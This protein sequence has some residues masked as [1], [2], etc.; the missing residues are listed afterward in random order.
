MNI[1][2]RFLTAPLNCKQTDNIIFSRTKNR[3]RP[4]RAEKKCSKKLF[5]IIHQFSP[6]L[7]KRVNF[8]TLLSFGLW[9]ELRHLAHVLII[10]SEKRIKFVATSPNFWEGKSLNFRQTLKVKFLSLLEKCCFFHWKVFFAFP[11]FDRPEFFRA[12]Q[13]F[14]DLPLSR[15]NSETTSTGRNVATSSSLTSSTSSRSPDQVFVFNSEWFCFGSV[16]I[17]REKVKN[18]GEKIGIKRFWPKR[19]LIERWFIAFMV[20]RIWSKNEFAETKN[21]KGWSDGRCRSRPTTTKTRFLVGTELIRFNKICPSCK[22]ASW[23]L[24]KKRRFVSFFSLGES[25]SGNCLVSFLHLLILLLQRVFLGAWFFCR[26][27]FFY[28]LEQFVEPVFQ[29]GSSHNKT[30][31]SSGSKMKVRKWFIATNNNNTNHYRWL[32]LNASA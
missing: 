3:R 19:V 11:E 18:F 2:T 13:F 6:Q 20:R 21:K 9:L 32:G 10:F 1:A 27:C 28:K 30:K 16:F 5:V 25:I 15:K 26:K 29:N 14:G 12:G 17:F 22:K 23:A 8:F 7:I 24:V 4:R 31:G